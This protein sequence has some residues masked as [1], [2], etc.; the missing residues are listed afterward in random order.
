MFTHECRTI[1]TTKLLIAHKIQI[2]IKANNRETCNC[3]RILIF[4]GWNIVM[5]CT[6]CLL[7][8]PPEQDCSSSASWAEGGAAGRLLHWVTLHWV[9]IS[10]Q[11]CWFNG[12]FTQLWWQGV[13]RNTLRPLHFLPRA[14]LRDTRL[15]KMTGCISIQALH[16]LC[17]SVCAR[18]AIIV[19]WQRAMALCQ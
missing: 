16:V 4:H 19:H 5:T 1:Q 6:V 15:A 10:N 18:C 3:F 13:T 14:L 2:Q 7:L 11:A 17:G 12:S 9:T 8:V